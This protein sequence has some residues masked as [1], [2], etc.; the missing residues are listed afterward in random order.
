[1]GRVLL[2]G[3]IIV[4][5]V[6]IGVSIFVPQENNISNVITEFENSVES[7]NIVN[8]GQIENIETSIEDN[9]NLISRINCKIATSIVNGL[10]SIFEI[11]MNILRDV[12]G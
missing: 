1:M 11:G 6:L 12:I 7:G 8:D 10:N 5:L 9:S 4:L 3:S 2:E